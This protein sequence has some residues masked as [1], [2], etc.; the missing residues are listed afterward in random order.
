[1]KSKGNIL[2]YERLENSSNKYLYI[3]RF[4]E[5]AYNK[6]YV[7]NNHLYYIKK[8]NCERSED[9]TLL[10][11]SKCILKQIPYIF[12]VYIIISDLHNENNHATKDTL[13]KLKNNLNYYLDSFDI[14]IDFIMKNCPVCYSKYFSKKI[15]PNI[16]I[17]NDIGPHYRYLI[18]IKYLISEI[19][20]EKTN[21]KYIIEFLEHFTEFYWGFLIKDKKTETI[22]KYLKLFIQINKRPKIIQCDNAKEFTNKI[23]EEYAEKENVIIIHSRPR[24]PQTNGSLERYHAEVHKYLYNFIKEKNDINDEI[25]EEGLNNYIQYYNKTVK[26]STKFAPNEIRDIDD[27]ELIDS[28]SNNIY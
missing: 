24:H 6:Y 2:P 28:I 23:I 18:D 9:G 8:K 12:E 14:I 26:S 22:L 20:S 19:D 5:L 21:F 3:K 1:M 13:V 25:L 7:E 16:K 15:K 17:I 10:D 4:K 11:K 27:S